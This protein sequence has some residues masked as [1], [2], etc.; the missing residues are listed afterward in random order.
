MSAADT[1]IQLQR[2]NLLQLLQSLKTPEL[3]NIEALLL[4]LAIYLEGEYRYFLSPTSAVL[5]NSN[6]TINIDPPDSEEWLIEALLIT[7]SGQVDANDSATIGYEV[8]PV[9]TSSGA[10]FWFCSST[11]L[12]ASII[13]AS[14]LM[15]PN[16]TATK[17]LNSI[18][19]PFWLKLRGKDPF[20]RLKVVYTTTA[21][22]GSRSVNV[23]AIYRRRRTN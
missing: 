12:G 20:N 1:S 4:E 2:Q 3:N 17:L 18:I 15:L 6:I 13:G 5:A 23:A 10:T 19:P 8:V 21:T 9:G 7:D 16:Y 22:V 14:T 11:L